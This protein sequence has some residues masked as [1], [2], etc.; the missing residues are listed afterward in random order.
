M[1]PSSPDRGVL[2]SEYGLNRGLISPSTH[3][4]TATQRGVGP[5]PVD[6]FAQPPHSTAG[7]HG[8]NEIEQL[9]STLVLPLSCMC[10]SDPWYHSRSRLGR[11]PS[12]S[13][14]LAGRWLLSTQSATDGPVDTAPESPDRSLAEP[15]QLYLPTSP[16]QA[17]VLSHPWTSWPE[18]RVKGT[19]E[20]ATRLNWAMLSHP[21]NEELLLHPEAPSHPLPSPALLARNS[22]WPC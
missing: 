18:A 3:G 10:R 7:D 17:V 19:M 9:R 2:S 1:V 11:F 8:P 13:R 16:T 12:A 20:L 21:S 5:E 22:V 4:L 14:R 6:P 15:Q